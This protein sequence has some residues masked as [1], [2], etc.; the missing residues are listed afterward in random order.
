MAE[1]AYPVI[2]KK[3]F[4]YLFDQATGTQVLVGQFEDWGIT[5]RLN[6]LEYRET[7]YLTPLLVPLDFS[8]MGYL[9]KGK[10]NH[11]LIAQLWSLAANGVV[12]LSTGFGYWLPKK[13][14][15]KII[16]Q[17]SDNATEEVAEYYNVVF[18]NH[19]E[20]NARGLVEESV[21]WGAESMKNY[22]QPLV[23]DRQPEV[24]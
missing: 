3:A 5:D 10:L 16:T 4:I 24:A 20:H 8:F 12:D 6:V 7:G 19:E 14:M 18:F 1:R 15:I 2:N 13:S 9:S 17:F 23:P 11:T 21:R 22:T